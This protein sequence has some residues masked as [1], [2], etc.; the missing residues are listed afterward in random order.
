MPV[1]QLIDLT[2]VSVNFRLEFDA[3]DA[4]LL[5]TTGGVGYL[6][7][8]AYNHFNQ[9]SER[10]IDAQ[11]DNLVSILDEAQRRGASKVI[12][13][14]NPNVPLYAPS[15]GDIRYLQQT[16]GYNEVEITFG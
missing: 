9:R 5:V 10:N 8:A 4:V 11:R 1:N 6:A 12:I 7:R 16:A 14:V 3:L 13:R 15:G 2:K